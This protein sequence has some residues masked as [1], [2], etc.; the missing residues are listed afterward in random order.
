MVV[1]VLECEK[2]NRSPFINVLVVTRISHFRLTSI[3]WLVIT[4]CIRGDALLATP[5]IEPK[6]L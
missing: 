3:L 5:L 2:G 1:V 4:L 6:S